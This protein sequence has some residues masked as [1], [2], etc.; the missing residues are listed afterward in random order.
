[1]AETKIRLDTNAVAKNFNFENNGTVNFG[2]SGTEFTITLY[3]NQEIKGNLIVQGT[4][5]V[6][7]VETVNS[8]FTVTGALTVNGSTILGNEATDTTNVYGALEVR[9]AGGLKLYDNSTTPVL[10]AELNG[11]TGAF[12]TAGAVDINNNLNVGGNVVLDGTSSTLVVGADDEN[13]NTATIYGFVVIG[14][15]TNNRS[16]TVNGNLMVTGTQ[17]FTGGSTFEGNVTFGNA[18]NDVATF[19]GTIVSGHSSGKLEINDAVHIAQDVDI[20]TTLNVDGASTMGAITTDGNVLIE[21]A[22][23]FTIKDNA[24]TPNTV[25]QVLGASGNT[26]IA[27]TLAVTLGVDLNYTLNVAGNI[28]LDKETAQSIT[29]VQA[30]TIATNAGTI[31]LNPYTTLEISKATNI[32]GNLAVTGNIT[33]SET[34]TIGVND[35]T[36]HTLVV[37][38]DVTIGGTNTR[39]LKLSGTFY[40]LAGTGAPDIFYSNTTS[41]MTATKVQAAIDELDS[42]VDDLSAGGS[43]LMNQ[44]SDTTANGT[45]TN[46]V[47]PVNDVYIAGKIMVWKNGQRMRPGAQKDYVENANHYSVDFNTAPNGVDGSIPADVIDFDYIPA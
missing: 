43:L 9:M 27:G 44:P 7:N 37:Y 35:A 42:R 40:N 25:F 4:E 12:I 20:D 21:T 2:S 39:N 36:N 19:E 41:G 15:V 10:K 28:T 13:N 32:N 38:G 23:D 6:N 3:G 18:D 24:A 14:S 29:S 31:T 46:F 17:T 30:L 26:T 16:L 5:T 22:K 47:T 1:M 34:E 8:S 33:V 11:A 45:L